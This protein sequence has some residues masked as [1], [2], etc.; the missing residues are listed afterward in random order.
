MENY[1]SAF[2]RVHLRFQI[3]ACFTPDRRPPHPVPNWDR[4]PD[5]TH[6]SHMDLTLAGKPQT[7]MPFGTIDRGT[8]RQWP[9]QT[10][11]MT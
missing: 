5:F 7:L 9:I 11:V 6:C 8:R 3:L 2:I 4:T 10:T 1:V